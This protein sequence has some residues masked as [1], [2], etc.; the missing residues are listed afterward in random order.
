MHTTTDATIPDAERQRLRS[1]YLA[2]L[3]LDDADLAG[4]RAGDEAALERLVVAHV[5]AVPFENARVIAG[6]VIRTDRLAAVR[7]IVDE[8]GGGLCY[9]LNGGL[10]WLL[11][12]LGR[13]V[14][15][16]AAAVLQGE[17]G[18]DERWGID[19]G[20]AFVETTTPAG[21]MLLDVGFGGEGITG[22]LPEPGD[23]VTT[24]TGRVYRAQ[25]PVDD[26]GA[27]AAA[28]A[29]HSTSPDAKFTRSLVVSRASADATRTLAGAPAD[30]GRM[31]ELAFTAIVTR[32]DGS[33][34]RRALAHAEAE[35]FARAELGFAAPVPARR[36]PVDAATAAPVPAPAHLTAPAPR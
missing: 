30:D 31:H 12:A 22:S 1:A 21:P 23:R 14:R 2:R 8:G 28:A 18:A 6:E 35:A 24:A 17:P 10:A 16:W 9:E 7:R 3:G 34:E 13:P 33:R 11:E 27:F 25:G 15:L 4:V 32:A 5:A 19:G 26:L 20:H 36:S 29:W